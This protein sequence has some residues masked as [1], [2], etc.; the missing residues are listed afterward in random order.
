MLSPGAGGN[1]VRV[2]FNELRE[3]VDIGHDIGEENQEMA[4]GIYKLSAE[5][6]K[7]Y[8]DLANVFFKNGPAKGGFWFPLKQMIGKVSFY[9]VKVANDK[10]ASVNNVQELANAENLINEIIY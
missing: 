5:A 8:Y 4:F 1:P 2:K 7:N 3:L 10:W 9:P 6:V